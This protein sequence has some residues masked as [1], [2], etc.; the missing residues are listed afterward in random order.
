[1]DIAG[2]AYGDTEFSKTKTGTAFGVRLL[3]KFI[4]NQM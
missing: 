1:L 2:V 3:L 4:E